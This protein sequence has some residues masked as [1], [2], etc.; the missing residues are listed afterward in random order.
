MSSWRVSQ[1]HPSLPL[2]VSLHTHTHWSLL[3]TAVAFMLSALPIDCSQYAVDIMK[4]TI[5]ECPSPRGSHLVILLLLLFLLPGHLSAK[6]APT[7]ASTLKLVSALSGQCSDLAPVQDV[8]KQLLA[9]LKSTSSP[10]AGGPLTPPPP[11]LQAAARVASSRWQST[12]AVCWQQW[13]PCTPVP[14]PTAARRSWPQPLQRD[15][16]H[17]SNRKVLV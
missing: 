7:R 3:P 17:T 6:A 4:N 13:R 9:A 14:S 1:K 16:L 12:A 10:A 5:S 8:L 2:W 15:W 11:P